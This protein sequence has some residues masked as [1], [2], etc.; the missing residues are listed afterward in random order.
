MHQT[1]P[2]TDTIWLIYIF[3][4]LKNVFEKNPKILSKIQSE[5]VPNKNPLYDQNK[6][7]FYNNLNGESKGLGAHKRP[8][9]KLGKNY[10][11]SYE[12]M[13]KSIPY[14]NEPIRLFADAREF[15][16][17][18]GVKKANKIAGLLNE[19]PDQ[20]LK[21][22]EAYADSNNFIGVLSLPSDPGMSPAEW[23][24]YEIYDYQA[25]YYSN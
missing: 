15:L 25:D 6:G 17:V 19:N 2:Q 1:S 20:G 18:M 10:G 12:D 8:I 13:P 4:S 22:I 24:A 14:K 9:A 11:L 5:K 23:W 16:E 3:L 21:A 7:N